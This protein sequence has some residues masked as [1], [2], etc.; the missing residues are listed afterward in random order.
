[1]KTLECPL[2][3]VDSK[4]SWSKIELNRWIRTDNIRNR[5]ALSVVTWL[6]GVIIIIIII[7]LFMRMD[8]AQCPLRN[9]PLPTGLCPYSAQ[10]VEK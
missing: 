2:A 9:Q 6:G 10:Y 1:M 5:K 3:H 4:L 8:G 7:I